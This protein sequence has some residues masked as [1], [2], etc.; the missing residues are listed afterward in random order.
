MARYFDYSANFTEKIEEDFKNSTFLGEGHNGI[1]YLLPKDRIIKLFREEKICIE[2]YLILK[3]VER[4][5]F[6]PKVY[7]H[8][9]NYIV[10]DMIYGERLDDYIEKYGLNSELFDEIFAMLKEFK[11]LGFKKIDARCRDIYVLKDKKIKVIDPKQCYK[12]DVR[13]PRHLMKGLNNIGVLE[14]F[15]MYLEKKDKRIYEKW[16]FKMNRYLTTNEK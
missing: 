11:N 1:V 15:F 16:K 7:Q 9:R 8:S 12:K 4:S 5:R 6:F 2:E 10:R 3:R 14:E 13:Y